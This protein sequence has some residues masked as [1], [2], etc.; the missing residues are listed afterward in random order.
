MQATVYFF[1]TALLES[2]AKKIKKGSCPKWNWKWTLNG[3]W[4]TSRN[5]FLQTVFSFGF[6][7]LYLLKLP[8]RPCA[9]LQVCID[10]KNIFNAILAAQCCGA[11][12]IISKPL[13]VLKV[14]HCV[15]LQFHCMCMC[16][17]I[18]RVRKGKL[19]LRV[20]W[21]RIESVRIENGMRTEN[22]MSIFSENLAT[23]RFLR[24]FYVY[25][26]CAIQLPFHTS[27]AHKPIPH[28]LVEHFATSSVLYDPNTPS[29]TNQ[30][31]F[32]SKRRVSMKPCGFFVSSFSRCDLHLVHD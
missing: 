3:K 32:S 24:I 11:S 29:R 2:S 13:P 7:L 1:Q 8:T 21:I 28:D 16:L 25:I 19:K 15:D 14:W 23:K 9:V 22:L 12:C 10:M 31:I 30:Q 4:S 6:Y 26:H 17:K 18:M 27:H 20:A 5:Q